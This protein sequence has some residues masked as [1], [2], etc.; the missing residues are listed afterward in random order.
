M[1]RT[2][3]QLIDW[4]KAAIWLLVAIF[5]VVPIVHVAAFTGGF[6]PIGFEWLGYVYALGLDFGIAVCAW[7]THW[8]TTRRAAWA[9]YF[10]FV[11]TDGGLNVAYVRPWDYTN[12]FAWLYAIFPTLIVGL[13]SI[14]ARQVDALSARGR[15]V[16]VG[17]A[18]M[19]AIGL[20]IDTG[21]HQPETNE[22]QKKADIHQWR[23]IRAGLNGGGDGLNADG[24]QRLLSEHGYAPV[25]TSTARRW[26]ND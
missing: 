16:G 26:A 19:S 2:K 21:E 10:I 9:C 5:T 22:R 4:R 23:K 12:K 13:L 15:K 17:D 3:V 24:V 14:L 8:A 1:K 7:F 20:Q 18:I 11:L 6:E 25:P